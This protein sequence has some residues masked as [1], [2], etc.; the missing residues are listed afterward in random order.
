MEPSETLD[1]IEKTTHDEYRGQ[2]CGNGRDYPN[3]HTK[4]PMQFIAFVGA[5]LI[6]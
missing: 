5:R 3:A 1:A 6:F 2:Q 4:Q